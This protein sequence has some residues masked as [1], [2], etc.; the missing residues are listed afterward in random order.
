VTPAA[1]TRAPSGMRRLPREARRASIVAAA[2]RA[3]APGGF[4]ETSMA[5][6]AAAAGVSHLIV[7]RHFESKE[8]IY[9]A[10]LERALAHLDTAL[11][12]AGASGRYGPTPAALLGSARSDV[13]GFRVLWRHAAREPR[14]E[15][16]GD[17]ARRRLLRPTTA[18]LG[19]LVGREHRRWA[20]RATVAYVVEAVLVWIEEGDPRLDDRFLAATD[21]SLR[22]GVRSWA[23]PSRPV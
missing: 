11:A 9:E 16:Y 22:A 1:S 18:A 14:F 17:A 15:Q 3:F 20:A 10:V 7:Y 19:P 5:D 2:A 12:A 6:I 21:A 23:K 8:Q 4:T 13:D